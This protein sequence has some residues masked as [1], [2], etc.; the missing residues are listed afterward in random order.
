MNLC[1]EWKN[2]SLRHTDLK[3]L[4]F[5]F[6]TLFS[7]WWADVD[8]NSLLEGGPWWVPHRWHETRNI[9]LEWCEC[10]NHRTDSK[11]LTQK[12]FW[13]Q[14]KTSSTSLWTSSSM[15]KYLAAWLNGTN[16][17]CDSEQCILLKDSKEWHDS[18]KWIVMEIS[19]IPNWMKWYA[20]KCHVQS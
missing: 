12:L 17:Q 4:S 16:T 1:Q 8:G 19:W 14:R 18:W 7:G 13:L 20:D 2:L 15:T 11:V 5:L 9:V 6:L 10:S 3:V